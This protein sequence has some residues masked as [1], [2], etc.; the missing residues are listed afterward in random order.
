MSRKRFAEDVYH[1]HLQGLAGDYSTDFIRQEFSTRGISRLDGAP[2]SLLIKFAENTGGSPLA[3]KLVV[4]QLSRHNADVVLSCL[5]HVRLAN[6]D[7]QDEYTRLYHHIFLPSWELLTLEAKRLLVSMSHFSSGHGG[8]FDAIQAINDLSINKVAGR[9]D[10]LW[11]FAFVEIGDSPLN[12]TRYYLHALTQYFI[13]S[14]I[15]K[16]L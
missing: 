4:G 10:E 2:D 3:L 11:K 6:Q 1:V 12:Q 5:R 14:D 9:L 13:L 16:T 7:S 15:V 8:T